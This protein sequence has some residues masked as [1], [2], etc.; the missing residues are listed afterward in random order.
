MTSIVTRAAIGMVLIAG[1][2]ATAQAEYRCDTP[3]THRDRRA[4]E[5]AQEGPQALRRYLLQ[6]SWHG[7][8]MQMQDYVSPAL[9]QRWEE[10]ARDDA[11]KQPDG[12]N[13]TARA[14]PAVAK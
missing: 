4:C 5:A 13:R 2:A 10:L 1:V 7:H 14:E 8:S 9:A 6:M 11:R 12:G 3:A